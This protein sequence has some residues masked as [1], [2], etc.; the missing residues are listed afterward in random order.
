MPSAG[1][2]G[3]ADGTGNKARFASPSDVAVDSAGN[4]IVADR[5]NHVIRKV[6]P[7]GVVTTVAGDAG[8]SGRTDGAGG[9]ARCRCTG[10]F[11]SGPKCGRR[12]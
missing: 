7:S 11:P 2:S 10:R 5:G 1:N 8:K 4:V 12:W 6:T 9:A 3:S